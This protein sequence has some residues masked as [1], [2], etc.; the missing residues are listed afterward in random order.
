MARSIQV[1]YEQMIS[2]KDSQAA[3]APYLPAA[4]T[5]KALFDDINSN[6]KVAIWRLYAYIVSVAI[7]LHEVLFDFF[8]AE[9]EA[10][11]KNGIWGTIYWYKQKCLAFQFGDTVTYNAA[12]GAFEYSVIDPSKQIVT[13]CSIVEGI[14]TFLIFKVAKGVTGA[15][16][17]LDVAEKLA[18]E[19]YLKKVRFAGTWVQVVSGSGDI[20]QVGLTIY[21]DPIVPEILVHDNVKIAIN[22]Y[23]EN[24]DFGDE[25]LIIRMIDE[26]QKVAGVKDVT[27][28]NIKSKPST[29]LPWLNIVR[30]RVPEYGYFVIDS[31]AGGTLDDT[32]N[33]VAV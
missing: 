31:N 18:L 33:Y 29:T 11:V 16:Q 22:N 5:Q 25:F 2:F 15:L 7:Y 19:S 1:I 23:V 8:R 6:S 27:T 17:A 14:N 13:R 28:T 32:L 21:Y 26:I 30:N 4:D 20:L 12:N 9:I 24:L 3:L 10:K